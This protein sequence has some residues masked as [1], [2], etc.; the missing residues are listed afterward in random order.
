MQNMKY[1]ILL[2]VVILVFIALNY[3]PLNSFVVKNISPESI[4]TL[5]RVIDGDTVVDENK[6]HYRLLGINTPEKGEYLYDEAT[7]FTKENSLNKSLRIETRGKD[8]YGRELAYL[9]DKERNI[10][11]EIVKAGYANTYF[12]EGKDIHYAEF[13][14]AWEECLRKNVNLCERSLDRCAS[15]IQL[16][17][18]DFDN[19]KVDLYNACNFDCNLNKW[20]I[21]D[22]GRK[23]FIFGNFTLKSG[24]SVY[25]IVGNKTDTKNTFYWKGYSYVWTYS[26]DSLFLRDADWKLVLWRTQGY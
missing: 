17:E 18:W 7:K 26:G 11:L 19:Q 21:K 8:L 16:K 13:A 9:Y 10:N 2:C 23:N 22:E 3:T 12:P 20:R 25:V 14:S 4:I 24:E 1:K 15:C 5:S 6:I